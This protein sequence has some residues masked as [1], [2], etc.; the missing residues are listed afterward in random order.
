MTSLIH[1]LLT[2]IASLPG[3]SAAQLAVTHVTVIDVERGRRRPDQTVLVAG[4]RIVAVGPAGR[5]RVPP[6]ATVVS[7]A[8]GYLIPGLWDLHTHLVLY[9]EL[10]MR[11]MIAAGVTG[12]RDMGGFPRQLTDWRARIAAGTLVGPRIKMAGPIL[13]GMRFSGT[14]G[15][16]RLLVS[17]REEGRRA[18]DSLAAVGVDLIK[19]HSYLPREAYFGVAEEARRIGLPFAG[20]NPIAVSLEELAAAGQ[21]S[22]EHE[23]GLAY[24]AA[25]GGDSIRRWLADTAEILRRLDSGPAPLVR[26]NYGADSAAT[27]RYV[28]GREVPAFRAMARRGVYSTPTLVTLRVV[29]RGDEP[30]IG[31]DPRLRYIPKSLLAELDP[32]GARNPS[33]TAEDIARGR[34]RFGRWLAMVRDLRRAGVRFL[35]GTDMGVRGVFP[36]LSIHDELVLLTEAGLTPLE[37]LQA[38][39]TNAVASLGIQDRAGAV[40]RGKA[41]DLVLLGADPLV[42]IRATTAIRAVIADGRLFLRPALDSLLAD[43][44]RDGR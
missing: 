25:P 6:G 41:A 37:A 4:N 17:T 31:A 11:L 1:L 36:G 9:G 5:I 15:A 19:V 40:A 42:D 38:A 32:G 8:N 13:D 20:H 14:I 22:L 12:A 30:E 29:A 10:G 35:A 7:G 44:E 43:A 24:A 39:T 34:E 27:A 26:L 16:I 3:D 18:V 33:P 28:P 23:F 2:A 21:R